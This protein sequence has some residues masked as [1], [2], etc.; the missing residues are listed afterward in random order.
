MNFNIKFTRTDMIAIGILA[1]FVILFAFFIYSPKDSCEVARANYKC[2]TVKQAMSEYC[3]YWG[4]Y[5]CNTAADASLP[6]V[7]WFIGNMCQLQNG[8]HQSG[9]DCSNLKSACNKITES[10]ICPAGL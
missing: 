1:A 7:E 5:S 3:V 6:D 9:L 8:Y 2:S 4:N 10:Q